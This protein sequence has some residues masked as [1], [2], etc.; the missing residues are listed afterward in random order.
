MKNKVNSFVIADHNKCVGCKLCEVACSNVHSKNE[1]ARKT[2]SARKGPIIPRIF[3]T[4]IGKVKMPIQCRHC[5]DMPCGKVCPVNAIKK[6]DNK[7]ILDESICIGCKT[8]AVA[9]PFGAIEMTT[10][11]KDTENERTI[12]L[13]CDLCANSDSPACVKVCPKKALRLVNPKEEENRKREAVV[14]TLRNVVQGL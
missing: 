6:V 7:V 12:A 13:K 3:V 14:K 9:C 2:I 11:D 10:I 1:E 5:E 4:K 8:C